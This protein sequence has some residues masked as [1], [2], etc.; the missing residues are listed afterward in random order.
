VLQAAIRRSDTSANLSLNP[1]ESKLR[2][3]EQIEQHN[4]FLLIS[5]RRRARLSTGLYLLQRSARTAVA[6]WR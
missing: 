6:L 2:W 3:S 4:E 1:D 5:P